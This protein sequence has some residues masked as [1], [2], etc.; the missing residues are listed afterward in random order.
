[1]PSPPLVD[2]LGLEDLDSATLPTFQELLTKLWEAKY[3]GSVTLHFA[4]GVPRSV[5]LSQPI[6]VALDSGG[7]SR[8]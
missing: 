3:H 5:V 1:M 2:V 7:G 6:Q 8:S 4:G